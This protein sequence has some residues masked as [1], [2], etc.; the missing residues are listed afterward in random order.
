M[1]KLLLLWS[2]L[3][4]SFSMFS[5]DILWEKSYGGKQADYLFDVISTPDYGFI[6]AGSSLS[7]KTGNKTEANRGDLD[8]W[9]WKMDE[10][11]DLDWQ[12]TLGGNG[13]DL[14]RSVVLTADGGYLL[15][16]S[17]VSDY[18]KED[19]KQYGDKKEANRGN[20]DFWVIKLN[21]KG[22]EEWQKTIGGKGQDDL[23]CVL[24]T[25][26]GGY[27][28]GGSSNSDAND[29]KKSRDYGGMD[30]WVVKIDAKGTIVWQQTFGG[31]YNDEL[32]SMCAT[33]DG[34]YIIGGSSNSPESGN[35]TE[36]QLGQSD[37]W[38]IKLDAKGNAQWQK[39]IGGTGDDQLYALHIAKDGNLLLAGNSNSES[40]E[41]KTKGNASGTDFWLVK[42]NMEDTTILWQETY[43]IAKTDILTS[44]VENDDATLLIGGYAQGEDVKSQEARSKNALKHPEASGQGDKMKKGTADY[45]VIKLKENGD[46]LW[47]KDV[48]SDGEDLLKKAIETRDGGYLLAGSSKGKASNDR[49]SGIGNS[50]FWVVKLKDKNKKPEARNKVE[51]IPN[52]ATDYTNVIVGYE[53]TKGTATLVDL[54]GHMLQQFEIT[55]RTVPIDLQGYPEGIY[56]VNIKTDKGNDGVKV[57]KKRR[58]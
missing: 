12:K 42:L 18:K 37:Y 21:A 8:Y 34:G 56:I 3:F 28:L 6:L 38:I 54:A 31:S 10:K 5:Q 46:E 26:D 58:E 44:L 43:N 13:Q 1:K 16:G 22:G 45:V 32:R 29:E 57:I 19:E 20:T 14:L 49:M 51:A 36:K 53:F 48:G 2:L 4:L 39:S 9:I 40:G 41:N 17:S 47:R 35:K 55:D 33:K 23:N 15:A 11:G 30:Y 25:T 7:K 52:P 27:L 24:R 50:D